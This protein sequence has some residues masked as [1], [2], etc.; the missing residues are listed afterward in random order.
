M[1][2]AIWH[3]TIFTPLHFYI[4]SPELIS[5]PFGGPTPTVSMINNLTTCIYV[6]LSQVRDR[7]TSYDLTRR[8]WMLYTA[9]NSVRVTCG[10]WI[11]YRHSSDLL[12]KALYGCQIRSSRADAC[13][14]GL[15]SNPSRRRHSKSLILGSVDIN[16][17]RLPQNDRH[18]SLWHDLWT[19][20]IFRWI[21]HHRPAPVWGWLIRTR[22]KRMS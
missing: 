14:A 13:T 20:V 10:V 2:F 5:R 15:H 12:C 22:T 8:L 6:S 21:I 3:L 1:I 7:K 9:L 4:H 18:H 11:V 19:R 17:V 16:A